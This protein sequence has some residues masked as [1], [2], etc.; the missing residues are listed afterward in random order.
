MVTE[1]RSYDRKGRLLS[2]QEKVEQSILRRFRGEIWRKF[3]RGVKE[4]RLIEEGDRIAV[5]IS[6]G[7]D[8][9]LL[10]KCMQELCRHGEKAFSL[11]FITMDPGYRPENRAKIEENAKRLGIPIRFFSSDIFAVVE[12][13]R[14]SPCYLCARMRRGYL[15]HFAQELGCNKIALGHHFDD[16]VE[17]I[18]MSTLY[19]AEF[20]TMMPKLKSKNFPGMELIRPLYLVPERNIVSWARYHGLEFLQC[21]CRFTENAANG[22]G[23]SKRQEIKRLIAELRRQNPNVDQNLFRSVHNVNLRTLIGWRDGEERVCFLDRY[24]GAAP[25]EDESDN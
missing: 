9:M 3:T 13:V 4:Y 23:S 14:Q 2:E 25:E 17:T 8:S 16:V 12:N 15:Y 11:E 6:G 18:L 10:A 22:Q 7:K 1:I 5:C 19:A 21:A 20:R 24:D